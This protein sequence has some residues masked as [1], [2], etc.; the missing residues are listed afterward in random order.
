MDASGKQV[1]RGKLIY[2]EL[3]YDINYALAHS[4]VE[5]EDN[6]DPTFMPHFIKAFS[7]AYIIMN[8]IDGDDKHLERLDL[9]RQ[10]YGDVKVITN[11]INGVTTRTV[12][13]GNKSASAKWTPYKE[14]TPEN[15]KDFLEMSHLKASGVSARG[16]GFQMGGA[17]YTDIIEEQDAWKKAIDLYES[18]DPSLQYLLPELDPPPIDILV[19]A[20]TNLYTPKQE[21]LEEATEFIGLLS[22][23]DFDDALQND[24]ESFLHIKKLYRE[25]FPEVSEEL[26]PSFVRSHMIKQLV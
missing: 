14:L 6:P 8:L 12:T 10:G 7:Q 19:N 4:S 9:L 17:S 18:I 15:I 1:E 3:M 16:G 24:T 25:A 5:Y 20:S 23:D 21:A 22:P 13:K 26:L 2:K 11:K